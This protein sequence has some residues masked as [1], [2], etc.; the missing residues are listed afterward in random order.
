VKFVE[1]EESFE[2]MRL[3]PI[4]IAASIA[5]AGSALKSKNIFVAMI[6]FFI[7]SM[8]HFGVVS[9]PPEIS[10][11][12]I[13]ENSYRL[14]VLASV[15][16]VGSCSLITKSDNNQKEDKRTLIS[17][18]IIVAAF[19]V[20][21]FVPVS[22]ISCSDRRDGT[23]TFLIVIFAWFLERAVCFIGTLPRHAMLIHFY[24]I[25]T[26]VLLLR[27][28]DTIHVARAISFNSSNGLAAYIVFVTCVLFFCFFVKRRGTLTFL[29]NTLHIS[30][31]M[32]VYVFRHG[33]CIYVSSSCL[34]CCSTFFTS[35]C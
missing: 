11:H 24:N 1:I 23:E 21:L 33:L 9:K 32:Q 16:Y 2:V 19:V 31:Q 7:T 6:L 17:S 10:R 30:F 27:A 13:V 35:R 3:N 28:A 26:R 25:I 34:R 8:S 14:G 5:Y 18:M 12:I 22:E 20:T 4:A 15:F 29:F